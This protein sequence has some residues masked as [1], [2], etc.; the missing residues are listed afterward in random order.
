MN[1]LLVSLVLL[2]RS[3]IGAD[4]VATTALFARPRLLLWTFADGIQWDFPSEPLFQALRHNLDLRPMAE[5]EMDPAWL[6]GEDSPEY[7]NVDWAASYDPDPINAEAW[8]FE[9]YLV[10]G[11][12][13]GLA[14][15]HLQKHLSFVTSRG[16]EWPRIFFVPL[17]SLSSAASTIM[18]ESF[19][20]HER[21]FTCFDESGTMENIVNYCSQLSPHLRSFLSH[22]NGEWRRADA[23]LFFQ[24]LSHD[25]Q[26]IH[27]I[28]DAITNEW[29]KGS[30]VKLSHSGANKDVAKTR[31]MQLKLFPAP[32]ADMPLILETADGQVRQ[33]LYPHARFAV[34]YMHGGAR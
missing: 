26:F 4:R 14:E 10:I 34:S 1:R 3:R 5:L 17:G 22:E 33:A 13:G 27:A 15:S 32:P 23:V 24:Q 19:H 12:P 2:S 30:N 8:L 25:R 18:G 21:I 20:G 9:G 7:R 16:W 29:F 28:A 31:S 6:S 11:S